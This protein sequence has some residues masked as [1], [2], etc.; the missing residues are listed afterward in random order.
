VAA[1]ASGVDLSK[2]RDFQLGAN[3]PAIAKPKGGSITAA[4]TIHRRPALIQELQWRPQPEG[5]QARS[6]KD[7][8]FSFHDGELYRITVN[9][10]R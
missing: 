4:K 9:Y 1:S 7:V 3:L 2:Y 8:V 5:L 6:E 10:D